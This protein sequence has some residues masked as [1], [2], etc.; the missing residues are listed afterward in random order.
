MNECLS[1]KE[2]FDNHESSYDS[3]NSDG[4]STNPNFVESMVNN[5]IH[6]GPGIGI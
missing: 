2:I 3:S 5:M 4:H 6:F 1:G